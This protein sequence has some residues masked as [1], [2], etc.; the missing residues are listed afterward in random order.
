LAGHHGAGTRRRAE[1]ERHARRFDGV[2]IATGTLH[3]PHQPPLPG[4]FAGA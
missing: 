1:P 4:T 2:L 3:H